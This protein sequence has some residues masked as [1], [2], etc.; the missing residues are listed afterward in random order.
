MW[1]PVSQDSSFFFCWRVRHLYASVLDLNVNPAVRSW[2]EIRLSQLDCVCWYRPGFVG[3]T[4]G[5]DL[6]ENID[7]STLLQQQHHNH[8]HTYCTISPHV[9]SLLR[10]PRSFVSMITLEVVLYGISPS[11]VLFSYSA[12]GCKGVL[13]L[14]RLMGQYCFARWRLS[15]SVMLRGR[16]SD[17][18]CTAGQY[19]YV[20]LG[21]HLVKSVSVS[22]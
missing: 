16:S 7:V 19:G 5:H 4:P 1:D 10:C 21:R 8:S 20:P 15:S 3:L 18:H 13:L 22:V 12:F 2:I 11:I 14:V 9:I 17:R 6:N